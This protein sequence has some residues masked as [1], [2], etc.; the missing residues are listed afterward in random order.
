MARNISAAGRQHSWSWPLSD[1]DQMWR[2]TMWLRDTPDPHPTHIIQLGLILALVS[3]ANI[4]SN[5]VLDPA[6]HI[7]FHLGILG[8][9]LVIARAAGTTW[10][11]MGLRPDRAVRG[12]KVGGVVSGVIAAA[13]IVAIAIPQTRELFLDDRIIDASVASVLFQALIR[14]PLATALYEEVLFRGIVFGMLMHRGK[15][16]TAGILTSVL[17]GLWHILPT[18]DTIQ[19]NPA[20]D[21]FAGIPGITVAIVGSVLGTAGAGLGFLLVRLYANSTWASVLMHIGTNSAAMLGSLFVIH[22]L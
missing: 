1:W 4:I 22:V 13:I 9:A 5:E 10:T 12:L 18:L 2:P 16:L 20:G 6:W 8:I 11:A 17:F 15:P 14:V 7:P 3:Y 21:V 19:M